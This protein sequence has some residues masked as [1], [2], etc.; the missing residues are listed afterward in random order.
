MFDAVSDLFALVLKL[1]A[2][3]DLVGFSVGVLT[4]AVHEFGDFDEPRATRFAVGKVFRR[5]R[6]QG[7]AGA[8]REIALE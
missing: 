5:G 8:L 1:F 7:L 4:N 3:E 2:A 6:I